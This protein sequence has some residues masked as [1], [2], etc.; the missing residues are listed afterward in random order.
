M[1]SEIGVERTW[2][3]KFNAGPLSRLSFGDRLL[4]IREDGLVLLYLY[5]CTI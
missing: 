1:S 3:K 4:E 2:I 5:Y